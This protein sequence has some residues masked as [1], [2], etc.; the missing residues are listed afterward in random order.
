MKR[1]YVVAEVILIDNINIWVDMFGS[2]SSFTAEL[3]RLVAV[4]GGGG[5]GLDNTKRGGWGSWML[6]T[7]VFSVIASGH[8]YSESSCRTEAWPVLA[9]LSGH[10][11]GCAFLGR[12]AA[13]REPQRKVGLQ[14]TST[15][16]WLFWPRSTN[17]NNSGSVQRHTDR[18]NIRH[19][20]SCQK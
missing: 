12:R 1:E 7:G 15:P 8:C 2:L 19:H 14:I 17:T 18:F 4:R 5:P 10:M 9:W 16:L 6:V 13:C 20:G 11:R 3:W